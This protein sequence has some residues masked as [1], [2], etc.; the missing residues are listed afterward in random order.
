MQEETQ[1]AK[2][3]NLALVSD[4]IFAV[5]LVMMGACAI[6]LSYGESGAQSDGIYRIINDR[7]EIILVIF[8]VLVIFSFFLRFFAQKKENVKEIDE[9]QE[10]EI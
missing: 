6:I 10:K 5:A 8:A 4:V 7:R 2:S 3:R 9:K 1:E